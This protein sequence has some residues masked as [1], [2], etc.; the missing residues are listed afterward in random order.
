MHRLAI[1]QAGAD[2]KRAGRRG[3][4]GKP[5]C[6]VKT[7]AGEKPDAIARAPRHQPIAIVLDLVNPAWPGRRRSGSSWEARLNEAQ[8][9]GA[10]TQTQRHSDGSNSSLISSAS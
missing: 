1:D 9:Y 7:V 4:E 8:R 5:V 10:G 6:P 3:N 2:I